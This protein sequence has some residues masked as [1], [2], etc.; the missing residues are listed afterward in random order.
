MKENIL[1]AQLD[2]SAARTKARSGHQQLQIEQHMAGQ[3]GPASA[4]CSSSGNV[5]H[6]AGGAA[7][8]KNETE[9]ILKGRG[10]WQDLQAEP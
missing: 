2:F 5:G 6:G 9:G 10:K 3:P 8:L 1:A 4:L 7:P